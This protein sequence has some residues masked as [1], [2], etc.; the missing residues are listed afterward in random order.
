MLIDVLTEINKI[1]EN[2]IDE[3]QD[4]VCGITFTCMTLLKTIINKSAI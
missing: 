3:M 2:T 4:L 1:D